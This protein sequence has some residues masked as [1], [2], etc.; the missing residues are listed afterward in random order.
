MHGIPNSFEFE[1]LLCFAKQSARHSY[2]FAPLHADLDRDANG[3]PMFS[4]IAIGTSGYLMF[5]A[6]WRAADKILEALRNE[7]ARRNDISDPLTIELAFAPVHMA[8]CD[9]LL[10]DGSGQ[11]QAIATSSTSGVPPYS[12]LFNL[13]LTEEQFAGAAAALNG[14]A[15]YLAIEYDASV[16][17]PVTASGRL[18]PQSV[19]FVPWLREFSS[20][21]QAGFRS[22]IEEAIEDGLAA[23]QLSLPDDPSGQLVAVLYDRVL[24]R[25]TELLPKLIETW[26]E[27]THTDLDVSVTLV[28]EV[29]QPFRPRAD[30]S[31]L[32]LDPDRIT[33]VGNTT[34]PMERTAEAMSEMSRPLRVKLG[35]DHQDA[36]LAWV[37]LQRGDSEAVLKP[38]DFAP[39]EVSVDPRPRPLTVTTGY[40]NGAHIHKKEIIPPSEDEL[41][42]MPQDLGLK[43]LSVDARPLAQAGARSAQIWLR[44]RPPHRRGEQ[45]HSIQFGDGTWVSHWWLATFAASSLRYLEYTWTAITAD[46]RVVNQSVVHTGSSDIILSFSGGTTDVTNR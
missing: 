34:L 33:F 44:Y 35:F 23:I 8:R 31:S 25:A 29:S 9:L 10:G 28:E 6:V 37:R 5:T 40:T 11:F 21:G 39:V 18:V 17:T 15:G 43:M 32:G 38:P 7:I 20:A 24:T 41:L 1:G 36:P 27:D 30:L 26:D 3:R 45:R 12:A 42:L 19:R 14:R 13:T 2:Y 22:A 4:V 46:G 16:I